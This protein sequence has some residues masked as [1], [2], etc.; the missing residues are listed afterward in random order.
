MIKFVIRYDEKAKANSKRCNHE[1]KVSEY[2]L[3]QECVE[4]LREQGYKSIHLMAK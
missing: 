1:M 2:T 4:I 3:A